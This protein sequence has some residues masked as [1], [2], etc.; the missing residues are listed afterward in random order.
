MAKQDG[1]HQI[2]IVGGGTGGIWTAAKLKKKD[3]S[4]DIA[5]IEPSEVHYYQSAFTLVGAG[6]YNI[7]DARR[8]T[9]DVM[10]SGVEWIKDKATKFDPENNFVSTEKSGNVTYDYLIVA[11]GIVYDNSLIEGLD[12]AFEKGVVCSNYTDPEKTWENI[13]KFRGGNAIFTQPNTPIK[14]SGAPQKIMYLMSDYLQKTGLDKKT[15]VTFA[16]PSSVI[17]GVEEV[18]STLMDVVERYDINLRFYHAPVKID[19]DK[20]I[21]Y[22]EDVDPNR[23]SDSKKDDLIELP[24]DFLHLAPPQR[25]AKVVE[26]SEL[27]NDEG[28]LDCDPGT[29]QHN[30]YR[31]IF[32][33]GDVTSIPN[34]KTGSAIKNEVPA[35]IGNLLNLIYKEDKEVEEYNGYSACPLVTAYDKMVLA[36]FDYDNNFIPDPKLKGMGVMDS[37]KEHWRLWLLKKY[38]LPYMY[39]NQM[40]TGDM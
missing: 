5:I 9:A 26:D 22:F 13:K 25:A 36:E 12:E 11:A 40:L 16:T 20:K 35:V 32:G 33:I 21:V 6:T 2:L 3:E 10:P 39:W 18:A 27:A 15:N 7:E 4:L 23:K 34:S 28:W 19:A 30:K 24:F 8:A 38:G 14:C 1:H 29:L 37:S 17:F 31:N